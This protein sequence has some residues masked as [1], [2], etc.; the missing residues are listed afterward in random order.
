MTAPAAANDARHPDA[1]TVTSVRHY[2]DDL[3]AFRVER[4]ASFRFRSGEFTMIGL[5]GENGRPILRA[6]SVASPVWDEELEFYSIKVPNGPL[7][8]RL[9]HVKP[10][11]DVIVR[12]KPTGTLVLDALEPGRRLWLV[13]TG[14][15]IAPFASLIRDPDTWERFDE[16]VLAHTCRT[17]AELA[18]G[19]ELVSA[20]PD[21]P[22]VGEEAHR[23][24]YYP[25]TTREASRHEGRVTDLMES[26]RLAAD[27]GIPALGP[28][29]RVMICGS[30]ALNRQMAGIC[31][32]AGLTEGSN[33][34]PGG[35][36][37]EKAFVGEGLAAA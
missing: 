37:V 28:D 2:T 12:R 13:A 20:L 24:R 9:R 1:L 16:V 11:D 26:G 21:D 25:T 36:V 17:K 18:Y 14:T 30:M 4:P 27:L 7:T 15:G 29:D 22:L 6:Y 33:A 35:Y 19:A 32:A 10:G 31:G 3:F 8:S 34:R 5:P 23:L